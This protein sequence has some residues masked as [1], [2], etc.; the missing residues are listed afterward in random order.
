MCYIVFIDVLSQGRNHLRRRDLLAAFSAAS[1]ASTRI[2]AEAQPMML[3]VGWAGIN[4]RTALFFSGFTK[5][6]ADFG[7]EEGKNFA[8][9]YLQIKS[10]Q[11]YQPAYSELARRKLDIFV[12]F[13]TELALRAALA[14]AGTLPIV[15]LAI[16]FDPFETGYVASLARP[17]GNVTGLFVRQLELAAKR[18]ELTRQALPKAH[19]LGLWWDAASH[20]QVE[21]AAATAR[22]LGLEPRLIEV[23]G[24]PRD[25]TEALERT[26]DARGE[27]IMIGASPE[28]FRD[29]A[30]IMPLLLARRTPAIAPFREFVEAGALMSYG[31][32][33]TGL[34]RD[35]AVYVD[36]IAKGTKPAELPMAQPTHFDMAINLKTAAVLDIALPASLTARADGVVE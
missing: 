24:Q 34:C 23:T 27:P 6:M 35:L 12:A 30:A 18:V 29:L 31:I 28:F 33:L 14:A 4:P 36:R 17:G 9:E 8:F 2:F 1:L 26:A 11:E 20:N 15:L 19:V 5:R 13:G 22:S 25:Y 10:T 3:R 32:D 16:D 21:A 7:Y